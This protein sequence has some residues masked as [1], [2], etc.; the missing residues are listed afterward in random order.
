MERRGGS[1]HYRGSFLSLLWY[2]CKFHILSLEV[3]LEYRDVAL[4]FPCGIPPL[5]P[6]CLAACPMPVRTLGPLPFSASKQFLR[7][8]FL[9]F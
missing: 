5:V 8:L 2:M 4:L 6:A 9:F 3:A 1:C 7:F